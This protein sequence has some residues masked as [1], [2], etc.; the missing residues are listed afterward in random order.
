M[1]TLFL[2]VLI[3]LSLPAFAGL[4]TPSDEKAVSPPRNNTLTDG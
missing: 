3:A 4:A 2:P 1:K